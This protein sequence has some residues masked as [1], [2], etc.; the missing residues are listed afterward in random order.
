PEPIEPSAQQQD[1]ATARPSCIV[2]IGASAGGLEAFIT[3]FT[4][5]PP[6]SGMAFILV[7]H[8]DPQHASLLPELLAQHTSMPVHAIVDRMP[9]VPD[10]VYL[11]P[12]NSTITI[13]HGVLFLA[14]RIE[15]RGHRMPI[16]HFL[17]SLAA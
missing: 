5:M 12:P 11:L 14:T 3:F 13:D 6:D 16:D 15:A 2:G 8:L 4:H 9:V 1:Q 17:H 7:Q 10:Q